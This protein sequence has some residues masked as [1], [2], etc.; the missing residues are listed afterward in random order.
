[1]R[2]RHPLLPKSL[3]ALALVAA[4]LAQQG[5]VVLTF[6]GDAFERVPTE[7]LFAAVEAREPANNRRYK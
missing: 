3:L 1:M 5:C 7:E 2:N 6:D 4:A